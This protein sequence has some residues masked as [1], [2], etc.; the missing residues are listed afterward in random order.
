MDEDTKTGVQL[1]REFLNLGADIFDS[2]EMDENNMPIVDEYG[3]LTL[4]KSVE[5]LEWMGKVRRWCKEEA[6]INITKEDDYDILKVKNPSVQ[7]L[8]DAFGLKIE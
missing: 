5:L 8:E 7:S 1:F 3:K 4:Y 6:N 2:Y